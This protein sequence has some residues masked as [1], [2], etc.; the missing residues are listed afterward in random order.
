MVVIEK[1]TL[2]LIVMRIQ[3]NWLYHTVDNEEE[4]EEEDTDICITLKWQ[5]L[6]TRN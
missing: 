2:N 3:N 6:Y 4:E 5:L 1:W